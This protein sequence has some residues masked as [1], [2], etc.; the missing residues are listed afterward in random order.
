MLHPIAAANLTLLMSYMAFAQVASSPLAFEVA[1][2]KPH[3][4]PLSRILGFS[5]SGARLTLEA[6][7]LTGL[8]MEA[9]NLKNYQVAFAASVPAQDPAFY[10]IVEKAEGDSPRT[11]L[12]FRQMLQ[13]LLATRF[14]LK[15]HREMKEQPV[16]A[17]VIGQNGLK[18]KASVPGTVFAF[19]GGVN[20]RNQS[21]TA[22]NA[23]M[24]IL[25]QA[26]PDTFFVDRPVVDLTGLTGAYDFA[27][28]ATPESRL[29]RNPDPSEISI[30]TAV[31]EQLGLKLQAQKAMIEIMVVDRVEKPSAN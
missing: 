22:S 8:I 14:H 12:E 31:K 15:V 26:I 13:A 19:R 3:L 2:V 20:G 18:F 4:A 17:L 21:V 1:S 29:N 30:F 5:S 27:I 9:Y 16:Y 25:A 28:E 10:D 11:R 6:Y 7:P 24:E 23:T